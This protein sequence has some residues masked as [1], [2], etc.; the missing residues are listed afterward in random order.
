MQTINS[1]T[2]IH[3]GKRAIYPEGIK[4]YLMIQIT[5]FPK[6]L[7]STIM[8]KLSKQYKYK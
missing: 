2:P 6:Y 1:P 7:Y 5:S 3:L 8:E 4:K